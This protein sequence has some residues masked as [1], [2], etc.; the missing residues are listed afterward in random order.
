MKRSILLSV[1]VFLLFFFVGI[2]VSRT[3][4]QIKAQENECDT[5]HKMYICHDNNGIKDYVKVCVDRSSNISGHDD[6]SNDIIPAFSY[7][8][9]PQGWQ[10]VDNN[11]CSHGN[12]SQVDA[13]LISVIAQ[14]DQ[15]ILTNDC[16]V[17]SCGNDTVD[18]G[19]QCDDG[20]TGNNDGCSSVCKNETPVCNDEIANNYQRVGEGEYSDIKECTYSTHRWCVLQKDESYLAQAIPN[21]QNNPEG[22]PWETGMDKY[23][24]FAKVEP[25]PTPTPTSVP[26]C[27]GDQHLDAVGKNCVS[28]GIPG[29][30][31]P[32]PAVGGTQVLGASTSR[33]QV[34]GASTMAKTGVVEDA[35]FNSIFTLGSLLT[36][37][38]II[39]N[40][41]KYKVHSTK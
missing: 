10:L 11:K 1:F 12:D 7:W 3:N 32:P 15:S 27:T 23:C 40:S 20:N 24:E 26:V 33:G 17:S 18:E 38:G 5:T 36:S 22:K 6:D 30:P 28:F 14:G 37:F 29:A 4:L 13:T 2:T 41:A 19:E 35:I 34:L 16:V 39:K 25:T 9:C 31:T 8:D 21:N